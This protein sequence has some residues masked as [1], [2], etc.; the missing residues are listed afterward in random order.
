MNRTHKPVWVGLVLVFSF[1]ATGGGFAQTKMAY[2]NSQK[3]VESYPPAQDA[4]KKLEVEYAAWGQE[5]QKMSDQLKQMQ[6]QLEQ[7]SLL[8]SEAKKREK[9]QEIQSLAVKA[10]QYQQEKWGEQGEAFKRREEVMRPIF[11]QINAVI[12]KMGQEGNYDFVFDIINNNILY[13]PTKYDITDQVIAR[14]AKE[15]PAAAAKPTPA[16]K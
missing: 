13:A 5:L 9:A 1:I 15:T 7:Q 4:Q 8:L 16:G 11:D 3:V 12:N 14:L 10:Q 2:I 6:D